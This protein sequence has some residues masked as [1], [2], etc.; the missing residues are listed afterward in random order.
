MLIARWVL[1]EGV[2]LVS[3]LPNSVLWRDLR[4]EAMNDFGRCLSRA[5]AVHTPP[6]FRG[7]ASPNSHLDTLKTEDLQPLNNGAVSQMH[8]K[9]RRLGS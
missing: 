5:K 6:L 3:Q 2:D 1:V 8:G 7:N 4:L 9:P